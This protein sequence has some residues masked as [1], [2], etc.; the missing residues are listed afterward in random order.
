MDNAIETLEKQQERQKGIELPN[1][2]KKIQGERQNNPELLS[3][4]VDC[5]LQYLDHIKFIATSNHGNFFPPS[6]EEL[7]KNITRLIDEIIREQGHL[8]NDQF[9]YQLRYEH[10]RLKL[11]F[12]D[13]DGT[14]FSGRAFYFYGN[15]G[16]IIFNSPDNEENRKEN[17]AKRK[18]RVYRGVGNF[19][20]KKTQKAILSRYNPSITTEQIKALFE[21]KLNIA[22]L[23]DQ[24][25][26]PSQTRMVLKN[27]NN[28]QKPLEEMSPEEMLNLILRLHIYT[29]RG[30]ASF[31]F[32]PFIST[33]TMP[34]KAKE[35]AF[36]TNYDDLS[37]VPGILIMEV[38]N[39][40]VYPI[41]N[42]EVGILMEIKPDWIKA[43]IPTTGKIGDEELEE[44]LQSIQ[45]QA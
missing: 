23:I 21:G 14:T 15:N 3:K 42:H 8:I 37:G 17:S 29:E 20:Q 4:V 28:T 30:G 2:I 26:D 5:Y 24:T 27:M 45:N 7:I 32:D 31:I 33:S 18:I 39:D 41:T 6:E 11:T 22:H 35:Y 9:K 38:P 44:I 36:A 16:Y 25:T 40:L 34:S 13:N 19:S 1:L 12:K 10:G 43:F